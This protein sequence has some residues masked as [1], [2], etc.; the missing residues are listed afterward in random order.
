MTDVVG[1]ENW[2][3]H[4]SLNV[5]Q[6]LHPRTFARPATICCLVP[7]KGVYIHAQRVH[8]VFAQVLYSGMG[9]L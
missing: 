5:F 7:I 8:P 3:G 6:M 9:C 2:H 4:T 1:Y